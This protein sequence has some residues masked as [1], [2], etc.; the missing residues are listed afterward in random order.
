VIPVAVLVFVSIVMGPVL[1][2]SL[3]N[4]NGAKVQAFVILVMEQGKK[5]FGKL[6]PAVSDTKFP[7]LL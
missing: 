6:T 5:V 1:I 4:A 3:I 2:M 7:L